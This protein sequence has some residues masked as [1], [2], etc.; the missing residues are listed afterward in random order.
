MTLSGTQFRLIAGV[1]ALAGT[2]VVSLPAHSTP[3][4][5]GVQALSG[6]YVFTA[7]GSTIVAGTA[8]PKAIVELIRMNGDGTLLVGGATRSV[9]GVIAQIPP[10]GT[11]T[12][13]LEAD[14]RGTLVFTGGPSFDIFASPRG[15]EFWMIQTNSDNVF[16]G[17]V[18]RVSR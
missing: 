11:G 6:R 8:Q 1:A 13:T 12:Y 4:A 5:C 3:A 10:G 7:T 14:C 15:V 17:S 18:K 16:Q 9:S 2:L